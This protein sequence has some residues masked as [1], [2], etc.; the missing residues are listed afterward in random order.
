MIKL[1]TL[2]LN[3]KVM[4]NIEKSRSKMAIRHD[5]L[6]CNQPGNS[7]VYIQARVYKH[8]CYVCIKHGGNTEFMN[9]AENFI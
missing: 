6:F 9:Y 5:G 7:G 3:L 4:E 2:K 1:S 8:M